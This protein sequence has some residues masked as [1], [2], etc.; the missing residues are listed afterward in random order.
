VKALKHTPKALRVSSAVART[1]G[2]AEAPGERGHYRDDSQ[3][4]LASTSAPAVAL[5]P[6]A[7]SASAGADGVVGE[8]TGACRRSTASDATTVAR[9]SKSTS[10]GNGTSTNTGTSTGSASADGGGGGGGG[11]SSNGDG[12]EA[13]LQQL[14]AFL[15]GALSQRIGQHLGAEVPSFL[16]FANAA[17][18]RMA[19]GLAP[20]GVLFLRVPK[21]ASSSIAKTLKQWHAVA[22]KSAAAGGVSGGQKVSRAPLKAALPPE[23]PPPPP[24]PPPPLLCVGHNEALDYAVAGLPPGPCSSDVPGL[25]RAFYH[26]CSSPAGVEVVRDTSMLQHLALATRAAVGAEVFEQCFTFAVVRNPFSRVVSSWRFCGGSYDFP[27]F[28]R[29]LEEHA[30]TSPRWSW[31]QRVHTC[32]QAPLV[33]WR[34]RDH[35]DNDAQGADGPANPRA[36]R[37]ECDSAE[38]GSRGCDGDIG[39][40]GGTGGTGGG[41][42]G[43]RG[44]GGS[45]SDIDAARSSR[46]AGSVSSTSR[47]PRLCVNAVL[48][49][50]SLEQDFQRLVVPVLL[51]AAVIKGHAALMDALPRENSQAP[52]D[53]RAVYAA[54][55][56]GNDLAAA[57]VRIYSDDF[58][59]FG[60]DTSLSAMES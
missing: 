44:S 42:D 2:M 58:S 10:T 54:A 45:G 32:P 22:L 55:P 26:A 52:V 50:E 60:Y 38:Q 40:G 4:S 59:A 25:L 23:R 39:T 1:I 6:E 29:M 15:R 47:E 3:T 21:N 19:A 30:P 27:D 13:L 43:G 28:V 33:S 31:H 35:G 16:A 9:T 37:A 8:P 20:A 7:V 51:G 36:E 11:G 56:P 24:P 34:R 49:F 5:P 57:V 18:L 12:V 41:T 53:Y 46:S 14:P 17:R 48:R